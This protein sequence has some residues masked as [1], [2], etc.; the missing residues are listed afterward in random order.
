MYVTLRNPSLLVFKQIAERLRA[1]GDEID[2]EI[3]D[4][5]KMVISK[6]FSRSITAFTMRR[7]DFTS[8][9]A[10]I[11]ARFQRLF[12]SGWH[13]ISFVYNGKFIL[14][15]FSLGGGGGRT[16]GVYVGTCTVMRL[17]T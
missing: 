3:N 8:T 17:C 15:T 12:P 5:T 11:L 4:E 13:Q 2:K 16:R 14:C 6:L 9:C 7:E 1:I 10:D